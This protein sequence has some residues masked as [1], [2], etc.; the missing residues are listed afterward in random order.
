M[1]QHERIRNGSPVPRTGPVATASTRWDVDVVVVGASVAG[2]TAATLLGRAGQRVAL[3]EKHRSIDTHKVLCTHTIHAAAAPTIHRL[4]LDDLIEAAGGLRTRYVGWTRWGWIDPD[5]DHLPCY[6]L[7]REKLD[8][9]MRR[10]AADTPGV[11]LMTGRRVVGLLETD[12][13]M[14]GVRVRTR[15]GGAEDVRARLVVGADGAHSTVAKLV[16]AP[17]RVRRNARSFFFA[18]YGDVD[19]PD[20]RRSRFWIRDPDVAYALPNDDGLMLLAY[21]PA[22]RSL[23]DFQRDREGAL[24]SRFRDMPDG[25][26]LGGA[27]QES[28]VVVATDYPIVMRQPVPRPGVA[29]VGDAALTSDPTFGVGCEWAFR[30]GEW[31][32]DAVAPALADD[33]P[34]GPALRAYRRRRREL[35]GHQLFIQMNARAPA[36][37]PM[38]RLVMSAAARDPGAA[39]DMIAFFDGRQPLGRI[40][41]PRAL[42]R[43]VRVN[44]HH[45]RSAAPGRATS[46]GR[47]EDRA[48]DPSAVRSGGA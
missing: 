11:D 14:S 32:A 35:R 4:G 9:L 33:Q 20:R 2:T 8:P 19:L 3:V 47:T 29:L 40:V 46:A 13:A 17:E 42:A 27:R 38:D 37:T 6:N 41:G 30:S 18:Y 22:N 15:G 44:A 45:R 16:D 21:F 34:L 26:A 31:L 23:P 5:D 43:A 10:L 24:I 28:Q 36:L 7:R 25:P 1:N 12:G 48:K 39:A